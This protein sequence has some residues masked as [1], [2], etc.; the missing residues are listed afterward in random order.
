MDG[1]KVADEEKMF[2]RVVASA[3][4]REVVASTPGTAA[5]EAEAAGK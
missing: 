5:A 2:R 4:G 3:Q 1:Q